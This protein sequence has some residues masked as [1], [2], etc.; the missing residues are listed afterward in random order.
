MQMKATRS[1]HPVANRRSASYD[2]SRGTQDPGIIP[3]KTVPRP[4]PANVTRRAWAPMKLLSAA[5]LSR[6]QHRAAR[7]HLSFCLGES[8][9]RYRL[10]PIFAGPGC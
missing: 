9:M 3:S 6:L 7:T 4:I 5:S 8:T 10:R 2:L 1:S